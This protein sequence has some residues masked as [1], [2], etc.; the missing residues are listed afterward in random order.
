[1]TFAKTDK[2]KDTQREEFSVIDGKPI[3]RLRV[4]QALLSFGAFAIY[5]A[6]WGLWNL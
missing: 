4:E 1:M 3:S 2:I 5:S 6:L